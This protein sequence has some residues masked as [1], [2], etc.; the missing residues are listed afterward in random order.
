MTFFLVG[1][2]V[3]SWSP[4]LPFIAQV[5]RI[6]DSELASRP[7][8]VIFVGHALWCYQVILQLR[9]LLCQTA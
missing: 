4:H 8:P 2:V 1:V 7:R 3:V 9:T 5:N 6:L